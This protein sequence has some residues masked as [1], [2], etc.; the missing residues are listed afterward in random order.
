MTRYLTILTPKVSKEVL[1][2]GLVN[3]LFSAWT[4]FTMKSAI[5]LSAL[6][7]E[8]SNA[9][10]IP[11]WSDIFSSLQPYRD[12]NILVEEEGDPRLGFVQVKKINNYVDWIRSN[13][14]TLMKTSF[15]TAL[16][17]I[18]GCLFR[19]FWNTLYWVVV[20]FW[21]LVGL[22]LIS[23]RR[24]RKHYNN[25]YLHYFTLIRNSRALLKCVSY[26]ENRG[27]FKY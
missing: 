9:L 4:K 7:I 10:E 26:G 17:I 27:N 20:N 3:I 5:V 24:G 11:K 6:V 18:Q 25:L 1:W 23:C 15:K 2:S 13:K 8:C 21:K 19:N 22:S 14:M 16:N 12:E